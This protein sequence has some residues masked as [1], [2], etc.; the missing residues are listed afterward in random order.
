MYDSPIKDGQLLI[1]QSEKPY[2]SGNMKVVPAP[3]L[4]SVQNE[5]QIN[6]LRDTAETQ[7]Q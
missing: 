6:N 1:S 2:R 7:I 4:K 3:D 5:G